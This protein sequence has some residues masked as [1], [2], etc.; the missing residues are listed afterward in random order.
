MELMITG[1]G[2]AAA[3]FLLGG[4]RGHYVGFYKGRLFGPYL[5]EK[6]GDED[7]FGTM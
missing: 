6:E 7:H 5:D 3:F 4:M 1:A 2:I